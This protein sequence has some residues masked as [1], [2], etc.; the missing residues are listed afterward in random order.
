M[1]STISLPLK[2][3]FVI[4]LG[5]SFRVHVLGNVL[6]TVPKDRTSGSQLL[7]S[8]FSAAADRI[9]KTV[10]SYIKYLCAEVC[11]TLMENT[12]QKEASS[13]K[14]NVHKG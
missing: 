14:G 5:T 9:L 10:K 1:P 3:S 11:K 8:K 13:E 7:F 2:R 6:C 4:N 12:K